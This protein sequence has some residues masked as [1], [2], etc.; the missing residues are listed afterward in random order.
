MGRNATPPVWISLAADTKHRSSLRRL[1]KISR[2]AFKVSRV[3]GLRL[4]SSVPSGDEA[5]VT[6]AMCQELQSFL[7]RG[8]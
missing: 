6:S 1:Q 7:E 2:D 4:R 3:P 5:L 8:P